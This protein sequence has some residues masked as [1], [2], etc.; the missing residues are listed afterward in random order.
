MTVI[1]PACFVRRG[2][3]ARVGLF[4]ERYQIAADYDFIY[5][6]RQAGIRFVRAPEVVVN[7]L[8]GGFAETHMALGWREVAQVGR[9]HARLPVLSAAGAIARRWLKR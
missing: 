8:R 4:D 2:V 3:Y 9:R 1:H 5:R 6:C 7:V